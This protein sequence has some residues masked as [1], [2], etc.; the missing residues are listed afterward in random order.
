MLKSIF[1]SSVDSTEASKFVLTA[2]EW[3]DVDGVQKGLHAMNRVRVP[4]VK[5]ALLKEEMPRAV[6]Q[7]LSGF[8]ILDVGCGGG[9]LSEV[10]GNSGS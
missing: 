4:F 6:G 9:I 8:S 3:W 2:K 10:S 5:K 1:L 7:P